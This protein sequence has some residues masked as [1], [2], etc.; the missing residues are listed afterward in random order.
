[1]RD[2]STTNLCSIQ[3]PLSTSRQQIFDLP[4]CR[5]WP[6]TPSR[7]SIQKWPTTWSCARCRT[8]ARGSS[9]EAAEPSSAKTHNQN[10]K[11]IDWC[12]SKFIFAP[13]K[14][15]S[16]FILKFVLLLYACWLN[17]VSFCKAIRH[18]IFYILFAIV[19]L[20]VHA[21]LYEVKSEIHVFFAKKCD[22]RWV[23]MPSLFI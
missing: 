14:N 5:L 13:L 3:S 8:S 23:C 16:Y 17:Y 4:I 1:M 22:A 10:S 12:A 11:A 19:V 2:F 7:A 20:R 21:P 9:L 6:W 15:C 18:S